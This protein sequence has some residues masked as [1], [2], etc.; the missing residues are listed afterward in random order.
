MHKAF[1]ISL[2]ILILIHFTSCRSWFEVVSAEQA[3]EQKEYTTASELYIKEFEGEKDN[4]LKGILAERIGDCFRLS[5]KTALA[6]RWYEKALPFSTNSEVLYK[7]GLMLKS[8]EKYQEAKGVFKDYAF[9]NPIERAKAKKQMHSCD[10]ALEWQE[11]NENIEVINLQDIN[12][13][14][15]DYA[16]VWVDGK[17]LIFTSSRQESK[18]DKVYGWTGEKHSDI[19]ISDFL[20]NKRL[21]APIPLSDT[22][23]TPF[24][25]GTATFAPDYKTMYFTR[26]GSDALINDFCNIFVSTKNESGNWSAP[27]ILLL[28]EE[29][30]INMGQPFLTPDGETLYFSA[31][32]ND[33]YGDKDLYVTSKLGDGWTIPKNL[34]P[35]INTTGYE[36]FPY[37]HPDGRLY[38]ASDGHSGMGGL[39][40]FVSERNGKRWSN[41]ENLRHPINSAA[42]DFAI[43][44]QNYIQPDEMERVETKGYFSSTRKGG[45]GNDDVY[46]FVVG[47]PQTPEIVE[48][49]PTPEEEKTKK[50]NETIYML[51]AKIST[52]QLEFE[53]DPNSKVIGQIPATDAI[54]EILGLDLESTLSERQITDKKGVI[55]QVLDPTSE[56]KVSA[57]LNGYFTQ[58]LTFT[59]GNKAPNKDTIWVKKELVLEKIYKQQEIVLDN[60]YY[61]LDKADI[62]EDAK[63]TLDK[64]AESLRDNPEIQ[65]ELGSHTDARGSTRY[66][67]NLSQERAESVV[68]YLV[69]KKISLR[70]LIAKGYGEAELV[71]DCYD[72]V[73]CTEEQHQENRRTTFKVISDKFK[74][75]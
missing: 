41:P 18:G 20:E 61:D 14:A 4:L 3:F 42:D 2:I 39:D 55:I 37:I 6:E 70:R 1:N 23:N 46:Q 38:F 51:E 58:S 33:S 15:S 75:E 8:N 7:Y 22:L 65:L 36:G 72:G 11:E 53:D 45:K 49:E 50:S 64:L 60:I 34:G 35:E 27:Q 69:S 67:Q 29:D 30:S 56:Y 66:N 48:T 71:N 25:E 73:D 59:T 44:Y 62:R 74:D 21:A 28:F 52:K 10:L 9:N 13:T 17:Q 32:A 63:P 57:S 16:P 31:D 54:V 40:I 24:N 43:V 19:F 47:I 5:N 68:N 26:C 12:S